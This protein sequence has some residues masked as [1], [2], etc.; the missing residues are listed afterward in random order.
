MEKEILIDIKN[1]TVNVYHKNSNGQKNKQNIY[2]NFNYKIY[3]KDRLIFIDNNGS[4]K[5]LLFDLIFCGL[6]NYVFSK[7]DGIEVTGEIIYQGKNILIPD[8]N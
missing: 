6:N 8:E 4:G 2:D 7:G 1:L 5:S 3:K